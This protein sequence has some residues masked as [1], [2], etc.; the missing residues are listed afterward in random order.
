MVLKGRNIIESILE[1][2]PACSSAQAALWGSA[3]FLGMLFIQSC[4]TRN[5]NKASL[6]IQ[7]RQLTVLKPNISQP[8]WPPLFPFIINQYHC[9]RLLSSIL[10]FLI[11]LKAQSDQGDCFGFPLSL[12]LSADLFGSCC[13]LMLLCIFMYLIQLLCRGGDAGWDVNKYSCLFW[14]DFYSKWS[15]ISIEIIGFYIHVY[16]LSK[17][18]PG[19]NIVP[20][21]RRNKVDSF[22]ICGV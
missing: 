22:F 14:R 4:R 3:V 1:H 15:C 6:K 16:T 18:K 20:H 5:S 9:L 7:R 17:Q 21:R 10:G 19:R 11:L 2:K 13:K 12:S 8:V